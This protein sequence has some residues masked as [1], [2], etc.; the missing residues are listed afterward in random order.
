MIIGVFLGLA[1]LSVGI[2][3][4]IEL[5]GLSETNAEKSTMKEVKVPENITVRVKMIKARRKQQ[6]LKKEQPKETL[7]QRAGITSKATP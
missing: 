3:L 6:E 2:I 4:G 5:Y 7:L 1:L